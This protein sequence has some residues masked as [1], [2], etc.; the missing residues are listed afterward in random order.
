MKLRFLTLALLPVLLAACAGQ[1]NFKKMSFDSQ[2]FQDVFW[3]FYNESYARGAHIDAETL[4]IRYISER[5]HAAI[6][7][8]E[9]S[10]ATC[11]TQFKVNVDSRG[12]KQYLEK[13]IYVQA[14]SWSQ[15]PE[16]SRK[17]ILFHELAHCTMNQK[18]RNKR[19][20]G[21]AVSIMTTP[22]EYFSE[23]TRDMTYARTHWVEMLN[24]L[25]YYGAK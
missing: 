17:T 24:E 22:K 7:D 20:E 1:K 13:T 16:I 15:L 21:V 8:N 2:E 10:L 23:N 12:V 25:F 6:R 9:H 3:E 18:H 11:S 5:E 19:I 14:E 4:S